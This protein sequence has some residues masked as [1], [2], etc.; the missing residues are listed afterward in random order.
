MVA[1]LAAVVVNTFKSHDLDVQK[2]A[3]LRLTAEAVH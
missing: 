2:T 3:V 1:C